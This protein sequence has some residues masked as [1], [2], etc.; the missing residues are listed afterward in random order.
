MMS[1]DIF[2]IRTDI[3]PSHQWKEPL[4]GVRL[5]TWWSVPVLLSYLQFPPVGKDQIES[6]HPML[7]LA[8][9]RRT[10]LPWLIQGAVESLA[11]S[12]V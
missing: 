5:A 2:G 1:A 8:I 9:A 6:I 3:F 4:C 10:G 11:Q 7:T 12:T